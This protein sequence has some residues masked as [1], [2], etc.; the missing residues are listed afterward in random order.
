[1]RRLNSTMHRATSFSP[2]LKVFFNDK[3]KPVLERN[4]LTVLTG[5]IELNDEDYKNE[6]SAWTFFKEAVKVIEDSYK[7]LCVMYSCALVSSIDFFNGKTKDPVTKE[8]KPGKNYGLPYLNIACIAPNTVKLPKQWE[9]FI[10]ALNSNCKL[11]YMVEKTGND[12]MVD[13]ELRKSVKQENGVEITRYVLEKNEDLNNFMF[14]F[15][16][17]TNQ[18]L[19]DKLGKETKPVSVFME[20][21]NCTVEELKKPCLE[22]Q[23]FFESLSSELKVPFN[24][25]IN[26]ERN[27]GSSSTVKQKLSVVT[28]CRDQ[29]MIFLQGLRNY[30]MENGL[31]IDKSTKTIFKKKNESEFVFEKLSS[32]EDMVSKYLDTIEKKS[33]KVYQ[34]AREVLK[35]S[36]ALKDLPRLNY[37]MKCVEFENGVYNI[38]SNTFYNNKESL[39]KDNNFTCYT[40]FKKQFPPSESEMHYFNQVIENSFPEAESK[41]KFLLHYGKLWHAASRRDLMMFCYGPTKCGKSTI[42]LP[43]SQVYGKDRVAK[44]TN[45][46]QHGKAFLR[47]NKLIGIFDEF[48]TRQLNREDALRVFEA[49]EVDADEKYQI[50]EMVDINYPIVVISNNLIQYQNGEAVESRYVKYDFVQ[51]PASNIDPNVIKEHI[52]EESAAIMFYTNSLY[53]NNLEGKGKDPK[54]Y[55]T[56]DE[57]EEEEEE[58]EP[59]LYADEEPQAFQEIEEPQKKKRRTK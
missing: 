24:K 28:V 45:N 47:G 10:S 51:L 25:S 48:A 42:F 39:K 5:H 7:E 56:A 17:H 23:E 11:M 6:E 32:L 27:E 35:N 30:M 33:Y 4:N 21:S 31:R 1:M 52:I 44:L 29:R 49:G 43:F 26:L 22:L 16:N 9:E 57:E 37:E 2:R 8:M 50:Q 3:A 38:D 53:M 12:A 18:H 13:S 34:W 15:K 40:Y 14:M 36:F 46:S 41:K 59:D 20:C 55:H 58:E 54:S 19:C